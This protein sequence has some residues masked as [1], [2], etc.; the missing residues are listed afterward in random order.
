MNDHRI[1][2]IVSE[3]SVAGMRSREFSC[4]SQESVPREPARPFVAWRDVSPDICSCLPLEVL[5]EGT[6]PEGVGPGSTD[7]R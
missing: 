1:L 6:C 2:F 7:H 3:V 4:S 5:H